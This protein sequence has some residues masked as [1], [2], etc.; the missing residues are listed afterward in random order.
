MASKSRKTTTTSRKQLPAGKTPAKSLIAPKKRPSE[1]GKYLNVIF[2]VQLEK[3]E[4]TEPGTVA[5]REIRHYQK[6]T[7][8]F[9]P[10]ATLLP[11]WCF[12]DN[13]L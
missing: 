6:T 2:Q 1:G 11:D 7:D 10:Q 12:L 4:D 9:D 3:P 5:L 8:L 13:F